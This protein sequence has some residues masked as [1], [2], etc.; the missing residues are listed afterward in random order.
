MKKI[1]TILALGIAGCAAGQTMKLFDG[2]ENTLRELLA[3]KHNYNFTN[4][5]LRVVFMEDNV[6]IYN[7]AGTDGTVMAYDGSKIVNTGINATNITSQGSRITA[8]EDGVLLYDTGGTTG[9][10]LAFSGGD[11][12][13]TSI[14]STNIL[15][16]WSDLLPYV[17]DYNS[18]QSQINT[19]A[20]AIDEIKGNGLWILNG[21]GSI[22]P[23][24]VPI[25][26]EQYWTLNGDGSI[27]PTF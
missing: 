9:N 13:Q 22:T 14:N 25:I 23:S 12:V 10:L 6:L 24:G 19:N 15:A 20:A 7:A 11:M 17:G 21:D 5:N 18:L 4:L 27:T 2:T 8:L 26:P 1:I 16:N 3:D